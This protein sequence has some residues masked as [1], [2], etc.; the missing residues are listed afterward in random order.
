LAFEANAPGE[1]PGW[2]VLEATG[3]SEG[4]PNRAL[5]RTL[6]GPTGRRAGS[7]LDVVKRQVHRS[8]GLECKLMGQG[9][10]VSSGEMPVATET[11]VLVDGRGGKQKSVEH[12]E[13]DLRGELQG[14]P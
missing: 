8:R 4:A 14:E 2:L 12:I 1:S 7:G 13:V 10:S 5:G 11:W 6:R 3:M 9:R